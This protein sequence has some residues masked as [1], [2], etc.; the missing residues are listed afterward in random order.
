MNQPYHAT[1]DLDFPIVC[2]AEVDLPAWLRELTGQA[3]WQL[4]EEL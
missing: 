1:P 3:G 2:Q 4:L